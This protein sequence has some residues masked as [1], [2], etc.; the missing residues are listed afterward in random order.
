MKPITFT[1][2][3]H[4]FGEHQEEY[5]D[6]PCHINVYSD[7]TVVSCWKMTFLERFRILFTGVIWNSQLTFGRPYSP[8]L[9]TSK[10]PPLDSQ[11]E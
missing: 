6:L 2:Q 11:S 10:K 1:G 8:T 4:V 9:I 3:N 5:M 7:G